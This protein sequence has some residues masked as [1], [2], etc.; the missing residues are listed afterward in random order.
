MFASTRFE[1]YCEINDCSFDCYSFLL[2]E[3]TVLRINSR[4]SF[5]WLIDT[6]SGQYIKIV[7]SKISLRRR[8]RW[9][10]T[11]FSVIERSKFD[12][13]FELGPLRFAVIKRIPPY[14]EVLLRLITWLTRSWL[15]R[16]WLIRSIVNV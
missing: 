2:I 15:I 16:S 8:N 6:N 9:G 13:Y 12:R 11:H 1:K 5:S 4:N 7:H 14:R 10:P 3:C